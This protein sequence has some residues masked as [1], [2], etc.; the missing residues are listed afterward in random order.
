MPLVIGGHMQLRFRVIILAVSIIGVSLLH[1]LTPLHLHY[2]HDIFQRFYYLPIILSAIWFGFRG[3]LLCAIVVSIV[4]APHILFQWGGQFTMEMEKYLEILLYNVVGGLTGLLSQR[5]R[6]RTVELQ[7][8]AKGLEEAYQKLQIQS[9]RITAIEENLRQAEKLSLI[10][11]M[12]AMLAHEIRNPLGGIRGA[13]EI[14]MHDFT[15]EYPKYEF[16][17]IQLKEID[18]LGNVVTD[19]LRMA[20]QQPNEI[21]SCPVQEELETVTTLVSGEAKKRQVKLVLQPPPVPVILKAD[22]EKLRQA[23]LNIMINS[24]QATPPG[25]SVIISTNLYQTDLCEI[26]FRD[27]GAGIDAETMERIFEPFFTTKPGGTGLG[28]AITKKIIESHGGTMAVESD[29]GR[30]T[31]ITVR[32]SVNNGERA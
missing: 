26:Q 11:E 3:G 30:G 27:T 6:E 16:F 8:T 17:E 21:T 13:A 14:L 29:V 7:K 32:L 2:L 10:G 31:T 19:F 4:Y 5:E 25:G 24:L 22:G 12:S 18:R 20:R 15:P 9:E 1:Y 28:M 23:F